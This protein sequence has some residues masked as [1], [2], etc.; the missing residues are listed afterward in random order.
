VEVAGRG[1]GE[2]PPFFNGGDLG[3]ANFPLEG[4]DKEEYDLPPFFSRRRRRW[5]TW[6]PPSFF[7]LLRI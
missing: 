6:P 5:R 7:S 2:P 3:K 1:A 4:W